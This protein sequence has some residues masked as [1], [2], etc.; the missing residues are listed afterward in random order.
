MKE[1][2]RLTR[3]QFLATAGVAGLLGPLWGSFGP[4]ESTIGPP[5]MDL[6]PIGCAILHRTFFR[7][8]N[9]GQ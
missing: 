7:P 1:Q 9:R 4:P 5:A 3:R 6:A 8:F 2:Y